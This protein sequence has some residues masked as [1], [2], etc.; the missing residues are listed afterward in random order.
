[1]K[2]DKCNTEEGMIMRLVDETLCSACFKKAHMKEPKTA[3]ELANDCAKNV[4]RL[5]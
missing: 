2:C 4:R 1:M 3:Q 5:K